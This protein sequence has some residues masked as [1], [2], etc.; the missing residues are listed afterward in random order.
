MRILLARRRSVPL[1]QPSFPFLERPQRHERWFKRLIVLTT[2]LVIV[3]ILRGI[4]WERYVEASIAAWAGQAVRHVVGIRKSRAEIDDSWRRYR[5]LGIE[6]TRSSV[7]RAYAESEPP[8]Q[9][10]LRYAGMDP[11]HGLLRWGN[12]DLTLLLSS[13]VF[14]ADDAGCSY[15]FR[16]LTRSIWLRNVTL[17]NQVLTFFIVPDGPGLAAA[18]RGTTARPLD[19]SRQ[20]TNSWGLRGPEPDPDAPLRGIVL[21]DSFMQGMFVGDD[22]TPPECLRRYLLTHMKTKTRVSIPEYRRH[23]LLA[24]AVLLLPDRGRRP[25][26]ASLRDRE[27]CFLNDVNHNMSEAPCPAAMATG[28]RRSTGWRRSSSTAARGGGPT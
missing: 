28:A 16:P 7:E 20:T 15:R 6:Q 18:I 14:Q 8:D 2:C 10:L 21:G 3:L 19:T 26:P 27:R 9:R 1:Q 24:R 25:I 22:E 11:Q 5:Q 12:Y 23:G 17:R 4:P 13:K